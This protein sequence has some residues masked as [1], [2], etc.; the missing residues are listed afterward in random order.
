MGGFFLFTVLMIITFMIMLW[1]LRRYAL[2]TPVP[3]AA[4]DLFAQLSS[5]KYV[6]A[7]FA[8]GALDYGI[9]G[10]PNTHPYMTQP[11]ILI[12]KKALLEIYNLNGTRVA[13]YEPADIVWYG[14]SASAND[15]RGSGG[16]PM[17]HVYTRGRWFQVMFV[18]LRD[19]PQRVLDALTE[20]QPLRKRPLP[21]SPFAPAAARVA[22]D[23][24]H[25]GVARGEKVRLWFS[26][27]E[28]VV[29][30]GIGEIAK[31]PAASIQ[32]LA[33]ETS[34]EGSGTAHIIHTSGMWRYSMDDYIPFV[35]ALGE[36]IG[37]TPTLPAGYHAVP[38]NAIPQGDALPPSYL[39]N[40][41][42]PPQE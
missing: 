16:L 40:P 9:A 18:P 19:H 14:F 15:D 20:F 29:M 10:W 39:P 2:T 3:P 23:G 13:A 4:Q 35:I 33:A 34:T 38:L 7:A 5:G 30:R 17:L 41:Q 27:V 11:C 28:F 8:P 12:V 24:Q 21:Y 37:V 32:E 42:D 36:A 31:L 1:L 25:P 22:A 6:I 26:P